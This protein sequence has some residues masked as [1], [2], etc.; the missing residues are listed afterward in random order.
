MHSEMSHDST[1]ERAQCPRNR[2][3]GVESMVPHH[4]HEV[5][6]TEGW[7][8]EFETYRKDSYI[9]STPPLDDALNDDEKE[10]RRRALALEQQRMILQRVQATRAEK[11]VR[12]RKFRQ[13]GT[14]SKIFPQGTLLKLAV[15]LTFCTRCLSQRRFSNT[16]GKRRQLRYSTNLRVVQCPIHKDGNAREPKVSYSR[17][18]RMGL[19]KRLSTEFAIPARPEKPVASFAYTK[20][21][22]R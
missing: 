15:C 3:A 6:P 10:R 5:Q 18:C 14:Y 13:V 11:A 12:Q 8:P 4:V 2:Q 19:W 22:M 20:G 1:S 17:E 9:F 21:R 7:S 16:R